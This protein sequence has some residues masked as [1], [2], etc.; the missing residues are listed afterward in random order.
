MASSSEHDGHGPRRLHQSIGDVLRT[1][2]RPQPAA[3]T[4]PQWPGHEYGP[5]PVPAKAPGTP[6]LP[7]GVRRSRQELESIRDDAA[8]EFHA[9]DD[10]RVH[11]EVEVRQ[12]KAAAHGVWATAAWLL[13]ELQAAPISQ[14]W[15]EYPYTNRQVGLE[16]THARDRIDGND[17]P[18]VDRDYAAGVQYTVGWSFWPDEERPVPPAG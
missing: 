8:R 17:W 4:T 14:E 2:E 15:Y 10:A 1:P 12:A 11:V 5:T 13:G 6:G 7:E 3:G 18:D 16:R 9:S